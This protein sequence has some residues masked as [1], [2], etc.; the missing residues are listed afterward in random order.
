MLIKNEENWV[1]VDIKPKVYQCSYDYPYY[2]ANWDPNLKRNFNY[3]MKLV[4]ATNT[5]PRIIGLEIETSKGFIPFQFV[6][7]CGITMLRDGSIEGIEYATKPM[8][9]S[10][11]LS[12]CNLIRLECESNHECS[13]H[14]NYGV[15]KGGYA[16]NRRKFRRVIQFMRIIQ[17]KGVFAD[18]LF[19]TSKWKKTQK[20]YN[21]PI[22]IY[23]KTDKYLKFYHVRD[24]YFNKANSDYKWNRPWRYYW[25]NLD[26]YVHGSNRIELRIIPN[27]ITEKDLESVVKFFSEMLFTIFCTEFATK[28]N[29]P[30][31]I[32]QKLQIYK[33]DKNLGLTL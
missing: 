17:S 4:G 26:N 14:V 8:K 18:H 23:D 10:S 3:G 5:D 27:T 16:Y 25:L 32:D 7:E 33:W 1:Y 19:Y 6:Q 31:I 22:P 2:S 13:I 29:L 30:K 24:Y 11:A 20:D 15:P 9:I 12:I 21:K 28:Q